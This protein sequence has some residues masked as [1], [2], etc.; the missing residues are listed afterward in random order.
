[1]YAWLTLPFG[2]SSVW[3]FQPLKGRFF[4]PTI[5]ELAL[6]R[7][8]KSPAILGPSKLVPLTEMKEALPSVHSREKSL[9]FPVRD[10]LPSNWR[11]GH[12]NSYIYHRL[13]LYS[14][15]F[16]VIFQMLY[17]QLLI[18]A[19]SPLLLKSVTLRT[20]LVASALGH[21]VVSPYEQ[22]VSNSASPGE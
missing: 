18:I 16:P 12:K 14:P 11:P 17:Y 13:W 2:L 9:S 21:N 22:L 20:I 6:H 7:I 19:I 5:L 3:T 4:T 15:H 1:M 10:P 8:D